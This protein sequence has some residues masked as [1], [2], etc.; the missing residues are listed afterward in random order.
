MNTELLN[1][2]EAKSTIDKLGRGNIDVPFNS[3]DL[4]TLI[5]LLRGEWVK[6]DK[7]NL[8]EGNVLAYGLVGNMLYGP[9]GHDD[10]S[11]V[12]CETDEAI[13][14]DVTHYQIP[15]PPTE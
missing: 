8:P 7:D 12:F 15:K 4:K 1:K 6:V 11:G 13:L 3:E 14:T 5:T 10:F 2:L 9:L